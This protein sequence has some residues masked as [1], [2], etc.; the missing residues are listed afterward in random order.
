METL[1]E[2]VDRMV[3]VRWY[4]KLPF[5][6]HGYIDMGKMKKKKRLLQ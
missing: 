1:F 6:N 2:W 5:P 4:L 3:R